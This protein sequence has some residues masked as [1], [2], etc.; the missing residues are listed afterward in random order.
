MGAT[1]HKL[2]ARKNC[3]ELDYTR[4][5]PIHIELPASVRTRDSTAHRWCEWQNI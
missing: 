3:L 4:C 5:G 1:A 2:A